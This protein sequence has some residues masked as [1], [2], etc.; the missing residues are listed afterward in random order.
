MTQQIGVK[1]RA[2]VLDRLSRN[3]VSPTVPV[4]CGLSLAFLACVYGSLE[5]RANDPDKLAP[6]ARGSQFPA[7]TAQDVAETIA[8][9]M[10]ASLEPEVAA[11]PEEE[12][13]APSPKLAMKAPEA[14]PAAVSAPAQ[15]VAKLETKPELRSETTVV[16]QQAALEESEATPLPPRRPGK[17]AALVSRAEEALARRLAHRDGEEAANTAI[18]NR[19][20]FE[21]LFG[22]SSAPAEKQGQA[23]AY[24]SPEAGGGVTSIAKATESQDSAKLGSDRF[25]AVYDISAGA[26]YLPDGRKLEA[27]SGLGESFDNPSQVHTRMRGPTP[28]ALYSLTPR[29]ALFHGVAALRLTPISGNVFGR[30]GLLAH[31]YMLGPRGDSNGCVSFRD[32]QAFLRAFQSGQVKRLAVVAHL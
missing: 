7:A 24:A 2:L 23:L 10:R 13:P 30:S 4:V 20:I 28:P 27:H 31:T 29:E 5:P 8:M 15:K 16:P 18:D 9:G 32:Y 3:I 25:T 22:R 1:M 12:A 6:T 21:K 17:I 26:V 19:N 11:L 14:A